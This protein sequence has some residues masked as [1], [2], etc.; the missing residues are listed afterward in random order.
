MR[1][2]L[3]DEGR[4]INPEADRYLGMECIFNPR[5]TS[6]KYLD[7]RVWN[8]FRECYAL[9]AI[10]KRFYCLPTLTSDRGCRAT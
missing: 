9:P 1:R 5:N 6:A 3:E 7:E 8:C 10:M 4:I 2:Q